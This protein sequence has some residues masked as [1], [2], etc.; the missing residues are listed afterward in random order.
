MAKGEMDEVA[1]LVESLR[2]VCKD[3]GESAPSQ[4][5]LEEWARRIYRD[6]GGSRIYYPKKASVAGKA[7]S[8]GAALASGASPQE[9]IRAAGLSRTTGYRILSRPWAVR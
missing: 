1:S 4:L 6:K 5:V 2:L 8:L 7:W 3:A 9:A